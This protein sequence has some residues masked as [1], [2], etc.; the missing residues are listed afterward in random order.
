MKKIIFPILTLVLIA[1]MSCSQEKIDID[2]EKEAIKALIEK[3]TNSWFTKDMDQQFDCFIQDE[4]TT[5]VIAG[6]D[7]LVAGWEIIS[8]TYKGWYEDN[9]EGSGRKIMNNYHQIKVYK[10]CAWAVYDE[11]YVNE[12]GSE[13]EGPR[14]IRFLEKVDGEWKLVLLSNH[15]LED[16]EEEDPGEE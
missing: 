4:T 13:L 14:A 15:S 7:G 5:W 10:D 6:K 8:E 11:T 2:K 3:E 16:T 9:P 12:D 1:G